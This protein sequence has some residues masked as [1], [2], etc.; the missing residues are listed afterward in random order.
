MQYSYQSV[1]QVYRLEVDVLSHSM[2][3]NAL[4]LGIRAW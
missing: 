1:S 3:V 2:F 4:A